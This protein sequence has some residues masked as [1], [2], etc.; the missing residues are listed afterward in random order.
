M[1]DKNVL[2]NSEWSFLQKR[3]SSSKNYNVEKRNSLFCLQ[4]LLIAILKA[5]SKR[6]Q[7]I[8]MSFY[9]TQNNNNFT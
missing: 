9:E 7:R 2:I 4:I 5:K 3:I 8:L 6:E 1:N